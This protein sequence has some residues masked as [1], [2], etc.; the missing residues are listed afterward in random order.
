MH[1]SGL[2]FAEKLDA[3]IYQLTD[4]PYRHR[5]SV[6]VDDIHIRDLVFHGYVIP[7]YS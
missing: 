1:N 4:M 5:K 2:I 6:K 7:S 3:I